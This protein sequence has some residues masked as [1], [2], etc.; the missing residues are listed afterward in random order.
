MTAIN[1]VVAC[2]CTG[3]MEAVAYIDDNR[4]IGGSITVLAPTPEAKQIISATGYHPEIED[5]RA[6]G[7]YVANKWAE[8]NVTEIVWDFDEM[9][10][11]FTIRCGRCHQQVQMSA[12]T[13]AGIAD[14]MAANL[15]PD[16]LVPAPDPV[17]VD[18]APG[19]YDSEGWFIPEVPAGETVEN[20]SWRYLIQLGALVDQAQRNI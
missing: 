19:R 8:A 4:P 15:N 18:D 9:R 20:V 1:Y 10:T 12:A 14:A 5:W 16:A 7:G 11:G 2:G 17:S 6:P 13:L 3:Q